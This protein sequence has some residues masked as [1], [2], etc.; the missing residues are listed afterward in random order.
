M[1]A[2][3]PV[4]YEVSSAVGRF[5]DERTLDDPIYAYNL[6]LPTLLENHS[7]HVRVTRYKSKIP[8]PGPPR[9]FTTFM[10]NGRHVGPYDIPARN[11]ALHVLTQLLDPRGHH[12]KGKKHKHHKHHRP[13]HGSVDLDWEDWEEW[14]P[15]W[16]AQD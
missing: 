10:V 12:K 4:D 13:G 7:L 11:G 8:L 16:A 5:D 15:Q 6:T 3:H 2:G 14:L 9:Y 1:P